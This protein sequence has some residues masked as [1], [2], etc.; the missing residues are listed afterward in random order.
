[1]L[2]SA[3]LKVRFRQQTNKAAANKFVMLIFIFSCHP[4]FAFRVAEPDKKLNY[5]YKTNL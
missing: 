3:I 2:K 4:M 5:E 1:M